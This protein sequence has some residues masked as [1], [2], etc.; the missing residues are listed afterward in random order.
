MCFITEME[1]LIKRLGPC[2]NSQG[3]C[4]LLVC[5]VLSGWGLNTL[6]FLATCD[7]SI[8]GNFVPVNY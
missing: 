1:T 4:V 2:L 3:I 8:V 5:T 6:T 7:P